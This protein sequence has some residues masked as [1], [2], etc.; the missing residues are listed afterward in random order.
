MGQATILPISCV[1]ELLVSAFDHAAPRSSTNPLDV[2][3]P[4]LRRMLRPPAPRTG[5]IDNLNYSR[6]LRDLMLDKPLVKKIKSVGALE[7][8]I[9][10]S[11]IYRKLGLATAVKL[12]TLAANDDKEAGDIL[13]GI[14]DKQKAE[15]PEVA[16]RLYASAAASY[17]AFI[18]ARNGYDVATSDLP[19]LEAAPPDVALAALR[20]AESLYNLASVDADDATKTAAVS[21]AAYAVQAASKNSY[22]RSLGYAMLGSSAFQAQQYQV[23]IEAYSSAAKTGY[24][25]PWIKND[26]HE[27]FRLRDNVVQPHLAKDYKELGSYRDTRVHTVFRSRIRWRGS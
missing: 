25:K 4:T 27:A 6:A 23:A 26:Y 10:N 17:E 18:R 14:G 19:A 11:I 24:K 9:V 15:D 16:K 7:C 8:P 13:D 3:T 2:D 5:W 12:I 20:R 21:A 1:P 22:L